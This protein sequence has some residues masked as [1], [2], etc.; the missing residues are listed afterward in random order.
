MKYEVALHR[1][2]E[3]ISVSVPALPGAGPKATP[4]QRR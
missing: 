3:G 1:S 4:K 2:E